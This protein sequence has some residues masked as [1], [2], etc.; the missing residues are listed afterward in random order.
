MGLDEQSARSQLES[1]GFEV[2]TVNEPT[3]DAAED[4]LVVGQSPG[5]GTERKPG[6]VITIRVARLA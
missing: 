5:A 3:S 2:M 4:G 1:A 6:A